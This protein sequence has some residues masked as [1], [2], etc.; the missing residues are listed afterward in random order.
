[1]AALTRSRP[2]PLRRLNGPD[3]SNWFYTQLRHKPKPRE[4]WFGLAAASSHQWFAGQSFAIIRRVSSCPPALFPSLSG[5]EPPSDLSR[6]GE[7]DSFLV[8]LDPG[9]SWEDSL[10]FFSRKIFGG[11]L[12]SVLAA[13]WNNL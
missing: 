5:N 12:I 6:S 3:Q 10:N 4:V 9:R 7:A 1:M 2:A 8:R 13:D 11:L